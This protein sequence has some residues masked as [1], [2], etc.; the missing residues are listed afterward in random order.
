MEKAFA[1]FLKTDR[2][3]NPKTG[4]RDY[5]SYFR[6]LRNMDLAK[7]RQ[8]V[9]RFYFDERFIASLRAGYLKRLDWEYCL[10]LGRQSEAFVRFLYG[11]LLKRLGEK[12]IYMR[13]LPGF[14]RDIGL[15]YVTEGEPKRKT[16]MLKRTVYPALDAVKGIRYQLDEQ[17]NLTFS[18]KD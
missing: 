11:H 6:V 7:R 4:E 8:G 2:F 12:S 10:E 9:S 3:R 1:A 15:G 16:E 18:P 14:L 5:V 13:S 17:G